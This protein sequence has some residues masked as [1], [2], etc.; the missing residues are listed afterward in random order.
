MSKN[1]FPT[2]D[3]GRCKEEC[4][5]CVNFCPKKV[6]E[7]KEKAIVKNPHNCLE[8]CNACEKI[9]PEKA[10]SFLKT[11]Q[12]EI[13]GI[14]IGING[15]N[16]AFEKYPTDFEKAFKE[17]EEKNYLPDAVKEKFKEAVKKEFINYRNQI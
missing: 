4:M 2:I 11:C 5:I 13:N 8:N 7:K 10:I 6:F 12:I 17:I 3:S 15:M 16:E 1:W 9:C 14:K